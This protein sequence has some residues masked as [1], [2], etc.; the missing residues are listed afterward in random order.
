[1]GESRS[2]TLHSSVKSTPDQTFVAFTDP[3]DTLAFV[4][5]TN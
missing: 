5:P 1:M 2:G 4:V 3:N